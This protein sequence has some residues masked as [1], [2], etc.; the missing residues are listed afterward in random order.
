MSTVTGPLPRLLTIEQLADQLGASTRHI[1][2]LVSEHRIPFL[3]VG[4]LVRFD[5]AEI[6]DWLDA[7]RR[8]AVPDRRDAIPRVRRV[9]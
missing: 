3:K 6:V 5:A 9:G 4:W 7:S 8:R 1:R 2:R